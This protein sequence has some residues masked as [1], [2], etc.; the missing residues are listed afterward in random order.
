MAV[1]STACDDTQKISYAWDKNHVQHR[2]PAKSASSVCARALIFQMHTSTASF[3]IPPDVVACN[4]ACRRTCVCA[5]ARPA[6][7]HKEARDTARAQRAAQERDSRTCQ[8][9]PWFS[10]GQNRSG[11]SSGDHEARGRQGAL[12][13]AGHGALILPGGAGRWAL[14][15]ASQRPCQPCRSLGGA[16]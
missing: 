13:G 14:V 11:G 12:G 8:P 15:S 5:L 16:P 6:H 7:A 1:A 9:C 3:I 2:V 10:P 4:I